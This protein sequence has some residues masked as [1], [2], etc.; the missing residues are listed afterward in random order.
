MSAA[1][2]ES[3]CCVWFPCNEAACA[4]EDEPGVEDAAW[5]CGSVGSTGTDAL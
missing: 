4:C 1:V 3:M 2:T 5:A